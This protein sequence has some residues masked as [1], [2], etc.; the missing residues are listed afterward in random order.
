MRPLLFYLPFGIPLYPY[1]GARLLSVTNLDQFDHAAF[2]V[3]LLPFGAAS[4]RLHVPRPRRAEF[5]DPAPHV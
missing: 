3:E 2:V 4:A 5:P 1:V